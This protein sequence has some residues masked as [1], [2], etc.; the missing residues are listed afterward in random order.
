MS[1]FQ[2]NLAQQA[3][4]DMHCHLSF[5][6]DP[7]QL[8]QELQRLNVAA[9]STTISPAEYVRTR[10]LE[11]QENVVLGVGAHPWWPERCDLDLLL[12]LIA[13]TRFVGEVGL[14]F[15]ARAQ[16]EFGGST[17]EQQL[18]IFRAIAQVCAAQSDKLLSI[19]A[20]RSAGVALDI[21]EQTGCLDT[22]TCV[23]HWFSGTSEDL[24]RA[25]RSGCYFSVN[26]M[27][28]QSRRGKEYIKQIPL[29]R[30]LLETDLPADE[31]T[32]ITAQRMRV[33]LEEAL[34][35]IEQVKGVPCA[36]V[37]ASTSHSLLQM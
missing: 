18:R 32:P 20:V 21:L 26:S 27:M 9:F 33:K 19:H 23:F 22:C 36:E 28:A 30:M 14:D 7:T 1:N 17:Q 24:Q 10:E 6:Q 31:D 13:Q 25:V 34:A 11:Q 5:A 4:C 12:E 35:A 15:G 3:L 8:A 37:I 16:D 2:E 29:Q